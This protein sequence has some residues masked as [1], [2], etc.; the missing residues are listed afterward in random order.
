GAPP[1][2]GVRPML[3]K[4]RAHAEVAVPPV[5]GP[6]PEVPEALAAVLARMLAKEPGRRLASPA[7]VAAALEPFAAGCDL[8]KLIT[9]KRG[10]IK[11][12]AP[13]VSE[14]ARPRRRRVL[15]AGLALAAAV[16]LAVGGAA[17]YRAYAGPGSPPVLEELRFTV[18]RAG[19][20]GRVFFRDLV[21]GGAG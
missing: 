13:P 8:V 5:R 12:L 15:A 16:A 11:V 14:V 9:D 20:N 4:V 2:A 7:E 3:E 21:S 1:F 19:D 10:D 18:R 17:L 6:R